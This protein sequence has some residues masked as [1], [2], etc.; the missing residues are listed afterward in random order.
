VVIAADEK[1]Y[2]TNALFVLPAGAFSFHYGPDSFRKHIEEAEERGKTIEVI[3][4]PG[5]RF[6]IDNEIDW[7][8]YQTSK[9]SC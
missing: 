3:T 1:G 7:Y 2:G 5:L 4:T 6:D 8:T 9:V